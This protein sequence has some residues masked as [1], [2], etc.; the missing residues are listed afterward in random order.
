MIE[1]AKSAGAVRALLL[2]DSAAEG[3]GSS[4]ARN[5]HA[6]I[7]D[8]NAALVTGEVVDALLNVVVDYG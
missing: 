5:L 1:S 2:L 3:C 8:P 7:A 6:L 4:R